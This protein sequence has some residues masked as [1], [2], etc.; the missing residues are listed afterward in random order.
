MADS[1]RYTL[2]GSDREL[3]EGHTRLADMDPDEIA[4]VTVYVRPRAGSQAPD[5]AGGTLTREEYAA[6]FGA[7]EEDFDAVRRFAE[8]HDLSAGPADRGRRSIVVSGRLADL[9]EAFGADLAIYANPSGERYRMRLGPLTLPVSLRGVVTGVFGL[10]QRAQARANFRVGTAVSVQY[11]PVQIAEQYD[12]PP[13]VNGTGECIG[14]V[15]LGGGYDTTDLDDYFSALGLPA[16]TVVTV[17]VDGGT[18]SPGTDSNSDIEVMLDIEMAAAI[19]SGATIAVYFAPNTDQGFLDAVSTAVHD[20]TNRP[21]VV[22]IS[23]GGPES[24]WTSQAMNEM[25]SAFAAGGT[26]GVTVTVASGDNGSTDGVTDGLQHVDF[27]ASAPHA[28]GCGGTSLSGTSEVVWDT[29]GDGAGGG[30]VSVQ[31]PLPSYQTDAGVPV[32][33][34]PGGQAGRGVPDVAGD[35]DPNTGYSIRADGQDTVVGGTSAVAPLWAGLV[36][37]LN[38]ALGS[39]VGFVH[40][41]L[42]ATPGSFRDITSG[43]NGA[44]QAGPGWDPCTGLGSPDG[45]AIL[46]ALQAPAPGA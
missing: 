46:T 10:D 1:E 42:Y 21:S 27:P 4:S 40:A 43:N 39:P 32:S 5:E 33:A 24:T 13:G 41:S 25:E 17:S 11:T 16:P 8:E 36:A 30:G 9:G 45:N 26:M 3:P 15:E 14:L 35:A 23:W 12:F 29:P 20:A 31:F 19:A 18:N 2:T 6:R 44:Y 37:R 7:S 38:Q 34:N 22:S 28:L